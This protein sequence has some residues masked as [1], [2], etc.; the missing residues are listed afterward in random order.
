MS[1]ANTANANDVDAAN[2]AE[3]DSDAASLKTLEYGEAP[4][5]SPPRMPARLQEYSPSRECPPPYST[6]VAAIRKK[7]LIDFV[8]LLCLVFATIDIAIMSIIVFVSAA[9]LL[10]TNLSSMVPVAIPLAYII[11]AC[12]GRAGI[13]HQSLGATMLYLA[14]CTLRWISDAVALVYL[15]RS[16]I[17]VGFNMSSFALALTL[18]AMGVRGISPLLLPCLDPA[19]PSAGGVSSNCLDDAMWG[20]EPVNFAPVLIGMLLPHM[21]VLGGLAVTVVAITREQRAEAQSADAEAPAWATHAVVQSGPPPAMRRVEMPP[22]VVL[23]PAARATAASEPWTA[24]PAVYLDHRPM[25][26]YPQM[27]AVYEPMFPRGTLLGEIEHREL[28]VSQARLLE[29]AQRHSVGVARQPGA[30][31]PH[32]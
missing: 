12:F 19:Y 31:R 7:C 28:V 3:R 32:R 13:I 25:L 17:G 6:E 8:K 29:Q 22:R 26:P 27:G 14:A 20:D 24:H 18:P 2:N 30:R 11:S 15:G 5:Y 23:G 9:V 21:V 4:A 10:Y 1:D 16:F